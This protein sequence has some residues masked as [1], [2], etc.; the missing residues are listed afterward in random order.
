M[1]LRGFADAAEPEVVV[2]ERRSDSQTAGKPRE[3]CVVTER[4]A[5]C[6]VLLSVRRAQ[7]IS[8]RTR[9]EVIAG[10]PVR[11]PLPN[12]SADVIQT[13]CVRLLSSDGVRFMAGVSVIPG[14]SIQR[15]RVRGQL[16]CPC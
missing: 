3:P 5:S 13:P 6:D 16:P 9:C 8:R 2:A 12:I 4:T 10:I 7:R 11:D 15:S 1:L 14:D